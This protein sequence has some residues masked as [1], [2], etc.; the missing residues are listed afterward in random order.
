MLGEELGLPGGLGPR[1]WRWR[2]PIDHK[3]G[4]PTRS[5]SSILRV[6]PRR[7]AARARGAR[8]SRPRPAR[9][10]AAPAPR[11]RRLGQRLGERLDH[12]AVRLLGEP[13]G[14]GLAAGADDAAGGA[15]EPGQVL[16]LAA[17]GAGG[18]LGGEAGRQ[19]QLQPEG[20]RRLEAGGPRLGGVVEQRQVA[21]EQVVGGRVGLGRVEQAQHRVAGAGAGGQGRAG[22]AQPRVAVD[23]RD[24][25]HREQVA[26][27]FVQDQ[28]EAEER[29]QA[30]AEA[31]FRFPRALGDRAEPAP[32]L[33]V[34]VE[35][36]VRLAVADAAQDD[37]LR[38]DRRSGHR[39]YVD[40]R[41]GRRRRGRRRSRT[42]QLGQK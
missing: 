9:P 18:Q 30:P 24:V 39:S 8:A 28:V 27:A 2:A 3:R 40:R 19:R 17:A 12:E 1:R 23:G 41:A 7:A 32:R 34:E 38:L 20:E 11:R 37:R 26:A 5:D 33:R 6:T 13:E 16:G 29:L 25:G 42:W 10:G 14:A 21:A 15:G 36:A 4:R 31:R 35:D 22:G